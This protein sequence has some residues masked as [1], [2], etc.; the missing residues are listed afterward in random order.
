VL[1]GHSSDSISRLLHIS[2]GT[3]KVHRRNIRHKLGIHSQAGLFARFL[4]LLNETG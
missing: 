3:V 4:S 2:T 1:Q